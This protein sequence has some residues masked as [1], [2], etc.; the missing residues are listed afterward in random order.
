MPNTITRQ[1]LVDGD[2]ALIVKVNIL[3]DGSG[4]ET[5]TVLIDASTYSPAATENK[6]RKIEY[7][8]NGF[9]ATLEWDGATDAPLISLASD[10]PYFVQYDFCEDSLQ[11]GGIVNNA[12]TPTGDVLITTA[13]LGAGDNGHIILYLAKRNPPHIR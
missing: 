3:G 9:T 10:H 6:L 13:G 11:S 1:T 5:D 7:C 12:T 4:E 2:R 8:L